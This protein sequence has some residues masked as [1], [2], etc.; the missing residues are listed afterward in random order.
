MSNLKKII[1]VIALLGVVG[2]GLFVYNFY[3]VFFAP[4]TAFN[5][6][7]AYLYIKSDASFD[8]VMADLTPLLKNANNF[9]TTARKKGY[10]QN[11]RG[12]K[13]ALKKGM[14]SNDIVNTLRSQNLPV[15]IS[16][17]NQERIENLAGRIAQQL[18]GDSIA[19]LT[20][21]T[22]EAFFKKSG[23]NSDNALAMYIPNSYE[24]FWNTSPERFR[25]RMLAEYRKFWNEDRLSKAKALGYTPEEVIALAAIVHK[26]TVKIDERPRVAGVYINRLRKGIR[27]Q[28]DPTVI[29]GMKKSTNDFDQVI[30]RVLYKD[31]ELD[32]PY[33]TYKYAGLPPGPISMPDISAVDAVLN[34]EKHNFLFFV[35]DIENFGY[36]KF[37]E[38][39][40]QHNANK[41]HYVSWINKQKIMR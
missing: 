40:A 28:A 31:L 1:V 36:H 13:Y 26:E 17:N 32:S 29:F 22:N 37:A 14:N 24:F 25:D 3:N 10:N 41:R 5:N 21:F 6:D 19:F 18:E 8:D 33:N 16:F 20:A 23:F 35:V 9:E 2:G 38:T 27:L 30:K 7:R 12:G 39:L 34:A 15:R 11:I 4:N